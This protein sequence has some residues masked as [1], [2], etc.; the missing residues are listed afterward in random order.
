MPA[1]IDNV[2]NH[3][4]KTIESGGKPPYKFLFNLSKGQKEDAPLSGFVEYFAYKLEERKYNL[5]YNTGEP[6]KVDGKLAD[7]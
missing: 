4:S 5:Q 6:Q 2:S 1:T 7:T 3:I